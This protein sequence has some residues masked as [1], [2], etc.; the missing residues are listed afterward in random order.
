M[1]HR[2]GKPVFLIGYR[3]TGKST[4]ARELAARLNYECIDADEVVERRAGKSIAAIFAD[5]G[6]SAFRDVEADVI[7]DLCARSLVVVALG[8]GAVLKASS[9]EAIRGAGVVVWLTAGVDTI[10][11]RLDA[12]MTTASRRPKLT[13]VGG[14]EEVEALLA[15]REPL[16][17]ECA[18]L[19]VDTDG[20]GAAEVAAEILAKL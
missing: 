18:T 8:G 9:R 16:Y 14:R 3:G 6:E 7:A 17:R 2:V 11:H 12:D 10:L 15:D 20:K 4:V 5:D 19:V 1:T 13:R